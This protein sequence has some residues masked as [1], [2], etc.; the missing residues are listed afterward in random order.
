MGKVRPN[1]KKAKEDLIKRVKA[2][3]SASSRRSNPNKRESLCTDR[4]EIPDN[5]ARMRLAVESAVNFSNGSGRID[6]K[7]RSL[8]KIRTDPVGI[9]QTSIGI[10]NESERQSMLLDECRMAA[11][12]ISADADDRRTGA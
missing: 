12:V 10:G 5:L 8:R 6:Q 1:Q 4:I 2:C 9:T 11:F 3:A 7:G